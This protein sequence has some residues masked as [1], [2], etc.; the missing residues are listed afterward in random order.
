MKSVSYNY[1]QRLL[2]LIVFVAAWTYSWAHQVQITDEQGNKINYTIGAD[3]AVVS[4][5]SFAN[6]KNGES[7]IVIADEVTY[8]SVVYPVTAIGSQV[9]YYK[10]QLGKLTIGSYVKYINP[11]AFS[12]CSLTAKDNS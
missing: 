2:L 9:F 3:T 4:S 11:Y 5:V 8:I 7:E 12:N 6:S 10:T 1:I